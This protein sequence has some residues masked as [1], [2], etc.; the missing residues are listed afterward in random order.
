[1]PPLCFMISL[2]ALGWMWSRRG[3]QLMMAGEVQSRTVTIAASD[4]GYLV[5]LASP[6]RDMMSVTANETV[7][8]IIDSSDAAMQSRELSARREQ[9]LAEIELKKREFRDRQI[10][11][12]IEQARQRERRREYQLTVQRDQRDREDQRSG[13]RSVIDRLSGQ[14]RDLVIEA[15]RAKTELAS[16][17]GEVKLLRQ[18]RDRLAQQKAMRLISS[19]RLDTAESELSNQQTIHSRTATLLEQVEA[20]IAEVDASLQVARQRLREVLDVQTAESAPSK[21]SDLESS[22]QTPTDTVTHFTESIVITPLEREL[23]VHDAQL[24]RLAARIDRMRLVSPVDGSVATIQRVPGTYVQA[25]DAIADLASRDD[26]WIRAYASPA[27]AEQLRPGQIVQLRTRS[28]G[29]A[30]EINAT[31]ETIGDQ[32]TDPPARATGDLFAP[33]RGVPVRIGLPQNSQLRPGQLLD[34]VIHDRQ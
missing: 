3:T 24:Q 1:M 15:A 26:L 33:P 6:L 9:L 4:A 2:V 27:Q 29:E 12:E 14:R 10:A 20:Q 31:I 34:V 32:M 11:L 5:E 22:I 18:N 28:P 19:H 7:I 21:D 8:A 23:A 16:I 30:W 13:L 17:G 25:G